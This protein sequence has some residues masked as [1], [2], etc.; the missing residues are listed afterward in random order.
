[1]RTC[2]RHRA[3]RPDPRQD[4]R[5]ERQLAIDTA[6]AH[7]RSA[8]AAGMGED[9]DL[10]LRAHALM[11]AG[12]WLIDAGASLLSNVEIDPDRPFEESVRLAETALD[13]LPGASAEEN[14][15]QAR[16]VLAEALL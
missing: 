9:H 10:L 7:V 1:M 15:L 2:H 16:V 4:G 11:E 8:V 5:V 14:L 3:T 13:S 12:D 6:L